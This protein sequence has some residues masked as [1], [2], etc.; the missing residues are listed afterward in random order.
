MKKMEQKSKLSK[1][2]AVKIIPKDDAFHGSKK[3]ISAEWWY[4]DAVF[5]NKYS[6]HIGF[7]T[8]SKKS[9][10]T[11]MPF[12]EIYKDGKLEYE[13]KKRFRFKNFKTSSNFPH[14]K[15]FNSFLLEFDQ[16]RYK[17]NDEWIYKI[18]MKM[19]ENAVDLVFKTI[20]KG[21]KIETEKESWAVGLPKAKVSGF[22]K[23]RGKMIEV[24]GIGYHDHNWNFSF[25]TALNYA[26]AWYW[27]KIRSKNFNIVWANIVKKDD[28]WD[29]IA[30]LNIDNGSFY[31]IKYEN[32][33]F[34][35]NKY[36]KFKRKKIPSEFLLNFEDV[37]NE[38]PI[39]AKIIMNLKDF[40]Y[41]SVLTAPYY[42]Y[43]VNTSGF[44]S[45]D[46]KKEKLSNMEIIEFISFK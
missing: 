36:F 5:S 10:G 24:N 7:R 16:D 3:A 41:S 20:T 37:V 42:R 35:P 39:N 2:I 22:I 21:W 23:L 1:N 19:G 9:L 15:V 6:V 26:K 12:L 28:R 38:L 25:L 4:F 17:K 13:G 32:I 44:I 31:N 27:G 43:H 14:V 11:I 46:N 30:V 18:K 45:V 8:F 29:L 33:I 40:H 34:K